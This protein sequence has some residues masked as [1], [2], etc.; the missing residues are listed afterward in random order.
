MEIRKPGGF[1]LA[2]MKKIPERDKRGMVKIED[3][4][5]KIKLLNQRGVV[6]YRFQRGFNNDL[7][8][9]EFYDDLRIFEDVGWIEIDFSNPHCKLTEKG[10]RLVKEIEIPDLV[11]EKFNSIFE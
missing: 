11:K 6:T 2:I 10:E 4:E 3:V 1:L 5:N 9:E 8:S 7:A